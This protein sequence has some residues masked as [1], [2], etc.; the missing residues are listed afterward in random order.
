MGP[1]KTAL[2][3]VSGGPGT[4]GLLCENKKNM[5][6]TCKYKKL[7][8]GKKYVVGVVLVCATVG[9]SALTL[10]RLRGVALL[11]QPLEVAVAVQPGAGE[12]TAGLCFE[13]DVFYADTRIDSSRV[14]VRVEAGSQPQGTSVRIS[15]SVQIDE[16]VV[17]VNLRAG[18]SQK[19]SRRY[20]LLADQA[21]DVAPASTPALAPTPNAASPLSPPFSPS[22]AP[23]AAATSPSTSADAPMVRNLQTTMAVAPEPPSQ[24]SPA[25][26]RFGRDAPPRPPKAALA[27]PAAAVTRPRATAPG[28]F[29]PNGDQG[30]PGVTGTA[31]GKSQGKSQ[32][33]SPNQSGKQRQAASTGKSLLKLDPAE[34]AVEGDMSLRLSQQLNVAAIGNEKLRA[35]AT[36]LWRAI[37][38]NPLDILRESQRVQTL[39]ADVAS[40]RTL[41]GKSQQTL[42][43]LTQRLQKA[44][45]ERF[46]NGLAYILAGLAALALVG[47]TYVW[48]RQRRKLSG[49]DD[50]W[51]SS[52]PAQDPASVQPAAS[53]RG[54][55]GP[56][57]TANAL[58]AHD[59]QGTQTV[60]DAGP[61]LA[62]AAR[63]RG[64]EGGLGRGGGSS[65]DIALDLPAPMTSAASA[66]G[67][68]PVRQPN[69]PGKPSRTP[70]SGKPTP[71]IVQ[72]TS[73]AALAS[74]PAGAP[75][76]K[77][78]PASMGAALRAINTE[79]LL[80]IRQQ[81]DFFLSLGQYDRAIQILEARIHERAE[82]SPLV[83]L[84]LLK[85]LHALDRKDEYQRYQ[86]DFN[87]RFRGRAA[88][89]ADF[90]D[91]GQSLEDEGAVMNRLGQVWPSERALELMEDNIFR[92]EGEHDGA[93]T[94]PSYDLAAFRELLMLHAIARELVAEDGRYSGLTLDIDLNSMAQRASARAGR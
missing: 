25:K 43:D 89:F 27:V 15:S 56:R 84:D 65:V 48:A 74:L 37:N 24:S 19:V 91:E 42:V 60:A 3:D 94:G 75:D 21:S 55:L 57:Q 67:T 47:A 33:T 13:A 81:A 32:A 4:A 41:T 29:R 83:Y 69:P 16:P 26:K 9:S 6:Q 34:L 22:S 53:Q 39:E 35:E 64:S 23:T 1:I 18:C 31:L 71:A 30:N 82:S 40:L 50:W 28:L 88:S 87:Q 73:P 7:L 93:G 66:M 78:F 61:A 76:S 51:H 59:L 14:R 92:D 90:G 44:E 12:D 63:A 54:Q 46:S 20:V 10:G 72:P 86:D 52:S 70:A 68:R 17:T 49:M 5:N 58:D 36:A 38:A 2:Q 80:D 79:E 8:V 85:L 11:G 45:S 62:A 77:A